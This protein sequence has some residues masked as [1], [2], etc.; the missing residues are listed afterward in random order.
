MGG[1]PVSAGRRMTGGAPI[2]TVAGVEDA[3]APWLWWRSVPTLL[4]DGLLAAVVL[5]ISLTEVAVNDRP[6]DDDDAWRT[7]LLVAMS[8]VIVFRRRYPVVVWV[9]SGVL[10]TVYG[11]AE[12]PDP[13]LPYAPLIAVYTVTTVASTRTVIWVAVITL[14]T[15]VASLIV[16]P[17]DDLL[18]WV[19]ALLSVTTAWLVGNNVRIQRAYGEAMAAR[20]AD[21]ERDRVAAA[22]RAAADERVR[23][24][25][26]LHDVAAHH[27]TVIALHAEAGQ[28]LLPDHPA[29]ADHEFT[30][31]SDVA[32]TT[33]TELRRVVGVL[34]EDGAVPL[35][36]QPGLRNLPSL[37]AEVEQAGV[38]VTL[39]VLGAQ[40]PISDAVDTSAY[41]IVQE[42]LTNVLRHAKA[43]H[44]EVNVI[45]GD[46]TASVEVLDDGS[47][48]VNGSAAGHGLVGMGERV[49]AFGGSLT[50]TARPEGGFAVLARLPA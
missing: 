48:A 44:A 40:R 30:I 26:E 42:A 24:A 50:A 39:Q 3:R 32:R 12:F 37:V 9:A 20:A 7:M 43:H 13:T 29:R 31:I 2:G 22:E 8:A 19:V 4:A 5:A 49:A 6:G 36:P 10:V 14:A 46:D 21:L 16:D 47:G 18:D 17:Y 28:S 33:L 27:V 15:V 35:A 25:R 45:Y 38:P 41:R 1:P 23:L 34:R 11:A